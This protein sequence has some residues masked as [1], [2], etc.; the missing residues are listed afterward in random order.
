MEEPKGR[1][2]K[3]KEKEWWMRE[4]REEEK[5]RIEGR[6]EG[7]ENEERE[8]AGRDGDGQRTWKSPEI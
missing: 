5:G 4:G 7:R 3:M 6:G 2:G 8:G 1:G